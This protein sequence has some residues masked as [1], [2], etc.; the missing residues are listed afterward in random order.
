MENNE[1]HFISQEVEPWKK[2]CTKNHYL[3]DKFSGLMVT[4]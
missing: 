1:K 4:F 3:H 2:L